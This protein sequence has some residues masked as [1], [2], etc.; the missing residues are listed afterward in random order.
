MET[1]GISALAVLTPPG[2][3][4]IAVIRCIGPR[5]EP[6][7]FAAFRKKGPGPFPALP[8]TLTYGHITDADGRSLDEV[9]V[10][11]P[12]AGVF[13]VNCHGGPAAAKAVCERLAG[14]GLEVVDADRLLEIQGAGAIERAARVLLRRATTPFAARVLLD[15]L[16]GSLAGAVRAALEDV[17]AGRPADAIASLD[18]LLA[19]W[20]TCGRFLADP[21]RVV[22]AG[23]PNA[24]KSTLL[25]RLVG[26]E[27]VITSPTPGTTRDYVEAEASLNGVPVIL[28]DTAGLGEAR[29]EVERQG[30]GRAHQ[31]VGRA[32]VVV[33]LL[34]AT[35]GARPDDEAM[36]RKLGDRAVTVWNKVDAA[37]AVA[38]GEGPWGDAIRLSARTG[39]GVEALNAA[40]PASLGWRRPAPGEAVPFSADQ[41]AAL[42]QA[43]QALLAGRPAD[44]ARLLA[45]ML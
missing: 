43:R 6:A 19:R 35:A 33:Y 5:A 17:A 34:D 41:A 12:A 42:D 10:A 18:A 16:S 4:G 20:R 44:A 28:V 26:T 15:Q 1:H 3:G 27:R 31:Q 11:F 25:N 32:A 40:V 7:V 30:V 13:E 45:A 37:G 24:G 9:I 38:A 23:R 2:R 36:L 14:L 22:L 29:E 8:G 39:E 21:P